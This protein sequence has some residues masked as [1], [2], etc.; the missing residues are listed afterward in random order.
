MGVEDSASWYRPRQ[1]AP[2]TILSQ[3]LTTRTCPP[4]LGIEDWQDEIEEGVFKIDFGC[5]SPSTLTVT[6]CHWTRATSKQLKHPSS[7]PTAIFVRK[8]HHQEPRGPYPTH[9][10]WTQNESQL[11]RL[12]NN[13]FTGRR[14][15]S[16]TNTFSKLRVQLSCNLNQKE[17]CQNLEVEKFRSPSQTSVDHIFTVPTVTRL[18]IGETGSRTLQS[19]LL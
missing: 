16:R 2:T 14:Y 4:G 8:A 17:I 3:A 19:N 18:L 10:I 7:S 11:W 5:G 13:I 6:H 15:K 12:I 9:Y 1:L